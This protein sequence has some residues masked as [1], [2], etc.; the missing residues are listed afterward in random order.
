MNINW[1]ILICCHNSA[2]RIQ[3]TLEALGRQSVC[4]LGAIEVVVIDNA[5]TDSTRE[6]VERF[7]FPATVELR[8]LSEP[9]PG[10]SF[11]RRMAIENAR[12]TFLCFMDDDNDAAADY[13]EVAQDI[14]EANASVCFCGGESSWPKAPLW[15]DLPLIA[16]FFSKA[17][18]VG[19]QRAGTGG[20]IEHGG[21]LWGA[22]LCIRAERAKAL[23]S[24]GFSPVLSGRVGRQVLSGEDGELTI[25]L[26]MTGCRGFYSSA[27]RLEH[28][29][30]PGRLNIKYFSKLFYGMGM[31]YPVIQA[32]KQAAENLVRAQ[33]IDRSPVPRVSRANRLLEFSLLDSC[34]VLVLY[35]WLGAC[36]SWGVLRGRC[37]ALPR[38]ASNQAHTLYIKLND[39][40][41]FAWP[42]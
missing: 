12:G 10:L 31:A 33:V 39:R 6:V 42:K 32:Y 7:D 28:R 8:I 24:V 40:K 23:Y 15:F 38:E 37:T 20:L 29:V 9:R 18:A 21:F 26:Q 27:L 5:S 2:D 11:A 3:K 41:N 14:F 22:G 30:N 35:I 4:A 17:V 36:F 19:P 1:S 16:R 34:R 13:L 25:L